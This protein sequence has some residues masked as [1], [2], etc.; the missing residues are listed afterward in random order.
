[1]GARRQPPAGGTPPGEPGQ[2]LRAW[3]T[4]S[5]WGVTRISVEPFTTKKLQLPLWSI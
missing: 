5:A 4:K 3:Y 2:Q 1:M